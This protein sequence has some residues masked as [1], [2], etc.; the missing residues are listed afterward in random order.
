MLVNV[1]DPVVDVRWFDWQ[2]SLTSNSTF[3]TESKFTSVLGDLKLKGSEIY[4][5]TL[6]PWGP[7]LAH[8]VLAF[9]L[10][11][12][13][14]KHLSAVAWKKLEHSLTFV[15]SAAWQWMRIELK[16]SGQSFWVTLASA[17]V[18]VFI[19]WISQGR[20]QVGGG[21]VYW[22]ATQPP[23]EQPPKH[24]MCGKTNGNTWVTKTL[25]SHPASEMQLQS[26][27]MW[28]VRNLWRC[29]LDE[30]WRLHFWPTRVS[31]IFLLASIC[32]ILWRF[33]SLQCY[34]S[35]IAMFWDKPK[36]T[37]KKL[38]YS[39]V[40]Y[41]YQ[42]PSINKILDPPLYIARTSVKVQ[43][44]QFAIVLED[45]WLVILAFSIA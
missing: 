9:S 25:W 29:T 21:G 31:K 18:S 27:E 36:A 38:M 16:R 37:W 45:D 42:P 15:G 28:F 11:S 41:W 30:W 19:H 24:I 20:I 23:L 39:L 32:S 13:V 1:F 44:L 34:S 4:N 5:R 40:A 3:D 10:Q 2:Y 12:H 14:C 22:V 33:K 7:Y 35:L 8:L 17:R 26:I 43:V 6:W